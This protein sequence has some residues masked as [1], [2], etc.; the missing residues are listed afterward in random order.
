MTSKLKD[1]LKV[2]ANSYSYKSPVYT[3]TKQGE[4]HWKVSFNNS[5][6]GSFTTTDFVYTEE[7]IKGFLRDGTWQ[8]VEEQ[9]YTEVFLNGTTYNVPN[10]KAAEFLHHLSELYR[11]ANLA[12][13]AQKLAAKEGEW[14]DT[15]K[16]DS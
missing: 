15:Y 2:T 13:E 4:D 10:D 12:L 14:L 8:L 16:V 1:V 6:D 11:Y 7:L 3:L 5:T 9:E